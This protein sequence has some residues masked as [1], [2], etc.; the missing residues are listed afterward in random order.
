M[1]CYMCGDLHQQVQHA[2]LDL[3]A[4]PDQQLRLQLL[5]PGMANCSFERLHES[6]G[7]FINE[8]K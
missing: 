5:E 1:L 7:V 6:W 8:C 2:A 3:V 4:C